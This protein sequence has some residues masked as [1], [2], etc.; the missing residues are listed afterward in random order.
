MCTFTHKCMVNK[1]ILNILMMSHIGHYKFIKHIKP[2]DSYISLKRL[3][4]K[5]WVVV[6]EDLTVRFLYLF[7]KKKNILEEKWPNGKTCD[8]AGCLDYAFQYVSNFLFLKKY[9]QTTWVWTTVQFI[10]WKI[11]AIFLIPF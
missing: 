2:E 10:S 8:H 9:L 7:E 4:I 3:E 6:K 11:Q 1:P 5:L